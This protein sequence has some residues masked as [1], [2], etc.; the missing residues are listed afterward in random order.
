[1]SPG[2]R[3]EE[4][5][6]SHGGL[7][8]IDLT[9][10]YRL[11]KEGPVAPT[12]SAIFATDFPTG[13]YKN[14]EPYAGDRRPGQRVLRLHHRVEPVQVE[15]KPFI[16]YGNLYYSLST[17]TTSPSPFSEAEVKTYPRDFVTV[18]LAAECPYREMDR[19]P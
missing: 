17:S 8:D 14:F 1:M 19:P 2:P 13:H 10:K 11:V 3:S 6:A 18:N 7:S 15:V 9:L 12:I 16:F 4:R 5:S